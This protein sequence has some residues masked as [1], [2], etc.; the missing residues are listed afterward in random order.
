MKDQRL[1]FF[2]DGLNQNTSVDWSR[3][4]QCLQS[5]VL[6]GM[7]RVIV[8][9]RT[10]YFEERLGSL[11][12]IVASA[13]RIEVDLY[14]TESGGELDEMLAL[15]GIKRSELLPGVIERARSPRLFN[16]VIRFRSN[17]V[18][19]GKVTVH[20]LL[21]EYGRDTLG[22]RGQ[23]SFGPEEWKEWLERISEKCRDGIRNFSQRG[24]SETVSAPHLTPN[25]VYARLSD[26]IDGR[27]VTSVSG[28]LQLDPVLVQHAL[29]AGLLVH[30]DQACGSSY[31]AL[32]E[33]LATWLDPIAGFDQRSEILRAA[34]SILIE[35]GNAQQSIARVLLRSWLQSQ[36]MPDEHLQDLVALA[37]SL[38]DALLD[39]IEQSDGRVHGSARLWASYAL[40]AVPRTSETVLAKLV[41]RSCRWLRVVSR[42]ID[43][44]RP[45]DDEYEK[46]RSTRFMERIGR[47]SSGPIKV[48]GIELE[49]VD[50]SSSNAARMVPLIVEGFPLVRLLEV[51]ETAAATLAVAD[52]SAAWGGLRWLCLLNEVDPDETASSLQRLSTTIRK[53][54]PEPGLHIGFPLRISALLLWLTGREKDDEVA[55]SIDPDFYRPWTYAKDYLP[56]PD[57][58]FFPLERR[59]APLTLRSQEF[60][61]QY[62]VQRVGDLWLDP[63]FRPPKTFVSE[64]TEHARQFDVTK[65]T[66]RP[67]RTGEDIEFEQLEP[68]LARCAPRT[69]TWL[70]TR[71]L[72]RMADSPTESRYWL[73]I[74][75]TDHILLTRCPEANAARMLRLSGTMSDKNEDAIVSSNLLLLEIANL[76]ARRQFDSVIQ[77]EL[78]FVP[79]EFRYVVRRP[80]PNDIDL[81]L[82][83]YGN[84][85]SKQKHLFLLL[86]SLR[87]VELNDTAWNWVHDSTQI[88]EDTKNRAAAFEI[89][90]SS[91]PVR[92][93]KSL[94]SGGWSWSPTEDTLVNHYGSDAL[95]EATYG[96]S[97]NQIAS[98]L[99]P[100]RLLEAARRRG[101]RPADIRLAVELFGRALMDSPLNLP[102]PKADLAVDRSRRECLPFAY[103]VSPRP[104]H[105]ERTIRWPGVDTD[106]QFQAY[107]RTIEAA[108]TYIRDAW[109]AGANL[110]LIDVHVKD[111]LAVL[112]HAPDAIDQWLAGCSEPTEEFTRRVRLAEGTFLSLCE[113]LMTHD[114]YRGTML[115]RTLRLTLTTK[116]F[117]P[118]GVDELVHMVYR[119]PD[120]SEVTA[121]RCELLDL[122]HCHNDQ[123]L[124]GI[125]FAASYN[126]R[127]DWL[128]NVI[129]ADRGS[130][131]TWR[132]RRAEVLSGFTIHNQLPVEGA[133]S[134]GERA[135]DAEELVRKSARFR[136]IEACAHHWWDAFL[137]AKTPDQ[138]YAAWV[139]FLRSS[140]RRYQAWTYQE[141]SANG[142]MSD[143][144]RLKIAHHQ[145]NESPLQ[146][147]CKKR[148]EK[149]ERTFLG[150]SIVSGIGP[151]ANQRVH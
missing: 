54:T 88:V 67:A 133:W 94:F 107:Q 39:A 65:L 141:P 46:R 138:A 101:S 128:M 49:L 53:R 119:V 145:I 130:T 109:R 66:R 113:V 134:E 29:G 72:Q 5:A 87:S 79:I 135:T 9:T 61:L 11:R 56:Q 48:I 142:E 12:N 104:T 17:L 23:N 57:R 81:L 33:K 91:D 4:L 74:R 8:S 83:K 90:D 25:Q 112:K 21:W 103:S 78:D 75:A 120:S 36:N 124:F 147:A 144:F 116:Y 64:F 110:Y 32:D 99:A 60:R 96:S 86:L 59:H 7:V 77:A 85:T 15:E 137:R 38:L 6:C 28:S 84:G 30:L 126:G 52:T 95:I 35:Q 148:G 31:L 136:W 117:G 34:L 45:A 105:S 129:A 98:R 97:F 76:D 10:H 13:T 82:D 127:T 44:R 139:L 106:Q 50:R 3:R 93:G 131:T 51:F 26:I 111:F 68:A 118:A 20:R 70:M 73:A 122:E 63:E 132:R 108:N 47:D 22:N 19:E 58:S 18:E 71:K 55:S 121:L 149:L 150:R 2:F 43:P 140:D 27:M 89:L 115:W 100:W 14:D 114:P 42:E 1:S 69:L 16:L 92:F 37:P 41:K 123:A 125:A 40:R 24:L 62:R 143:F 102:D 146:R 151:W 80:G